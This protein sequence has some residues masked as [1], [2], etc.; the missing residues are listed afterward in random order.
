MN[1]HKPTYIILGVGAFLLVTISV[2]GIFM[3]SRLNTS[4]TINSF[5]ECAAANLPVME[6]YPRQC[7]TPDGRTFTETVTASLPYPVGVYFSKTPESDDDFTYVIRV[8]RTTTDSN[9]VEHAVNELLNGP[10]SSEIQ[11]GLFTPFKLS[12]SSTC[13][14]KDFEVEVDAQKT[15]K[16]YLCRDLIL[17]GIGDSARLQTALNRTLIGLNEIKAVELYRFAD[18]NPISFSEKGD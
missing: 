9:I 15:A 11:L 13:D 18:K 14:D 17:G 3:A 7:A 16:I 10:S 12:G 8:E 6:S 2:I 1:N 4:T 5:E